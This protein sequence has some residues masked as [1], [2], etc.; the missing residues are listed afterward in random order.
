MWQKSLLK[1]QHLDYPSASRIARF[2]GRDKRGKEMFK[3]ASKQEAEDLE[4]IK[5]KIVKFS[6]ATTT[7]KGN[8]EIGKTM[9][10]S[11]LVCHKVG[12]DGNEIAPPLD[13]SANRNTEHLITAIVAPDEAVEG[14]FGLYYAVRKDGFVKQGY[15]AKHDSNGIIIAEAGGAESFIAGDKLLSHGSVRGRSF[16]TRSFGDLPEQSMVDLVSYIKTLK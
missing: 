1:K 5:H 3:I 8:P 12:Q 15:L 10:M 9:F 4:A 14:A 13:G 6:K 16:M 11:C 7:L 2:D